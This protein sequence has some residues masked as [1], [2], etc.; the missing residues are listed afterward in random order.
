MTSTTSDPSVPER[1]LRLPSGATMPLLGFGTW[2]ITGEEALQAT[3]AAVEAGYRHIDTA[4]V[5]GNEREVGSALRAAGTSRDDLFLTTKL[6]PHRTGAELETLRSSLESLGTDHVDLWLI[7]WPPNDGIGVDLWRA[8]VRAREEG[9]A[10]DIGVSNYS[11]GQID[12]LTAA[13]GVKPAV[14]QIE[15]SPKLFD[16]SVLDGHREREIVLEGYSALRGG[17]LEHPVIVKIAERLSRTPAQVIIRWHLQ[18]DVVVI[19]KSRSRERIFSNA[20][21]DAFELTAD[22]VSALDALGGAG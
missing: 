15:W 4:T 8:L 3:T 16:T 19:P 20:D 6:P 1:G 21:V 5:Y 9:L 17:T 12:E 2:Q 22:D 10:R 14:N 13:T 11:L 18:H 7:H